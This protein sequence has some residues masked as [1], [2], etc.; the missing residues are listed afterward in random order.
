MARKAGHWPTAYNAILQSRQTNSLISHI[1]S[2]KL[3]R[4]LPSGEAHT[5]LHE[6]TIYMKQHGLI[7]G[8]EINMD[9]GDDRTKKYRAKVI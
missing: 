5:A 2:A 4:A 7:K 9:A 3:T 8:D 6:I 1:E